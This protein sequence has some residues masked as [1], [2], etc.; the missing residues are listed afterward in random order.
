M[1]VVS[2]NVGK[3]QSHSWKGKT[4]ETG[5]YKYPV[6][7]GIFLEKL[8]V[9]GDAVVDRKYHGGI[10]KACYLYSH[11]HY[12]YWQDR[13]P[14]LDFH[15]GMMG[16]NLTIGGL[17]EKE[18]Y[19]GDVFQIG[20]AKI[21]ISQPRIPCRTLGIKFQDQ[22]IVKQFLN[23]TFSGCY[24]RVLEPGLV[25]KDDT[26]EFIE[27]KDNAQRLDLVFDLTKKKT[28]DIHFRQ[29]ALNNPF[30]SED[31]KPGIV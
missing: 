1:H 31:Y 27:R 16:E 20:A 17:N 11:D 4:Y 14:H 15:L 6:D 3:R 24:V 18:M 21:E 10:D 26:I 12:P 9:V 29:A 2:T 28:S 19:I 5:I 13:F 23:S 25:V 30:L 7:Q 8:D 22:S